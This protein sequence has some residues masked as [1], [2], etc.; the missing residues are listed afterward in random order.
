MAKAKKAVK[1]R[2]ASKAQLAAL[3]RGR[4][5]AAANRKSASPKRKPRK[6][7][8]R[9]IRTI[10][11]SKPMARRKSSKAVAK[12][13]TKRRRSSGRG[14]FI[15]GKAK[16]MIPIVKDVAIAVGGGVAGG[17]LANK[18]PI[19][20]PK[21]K[22]ALPLVAGILL[23]STLGQKKRIMHELGTGMAVIGAIALLKQFAP[24]IPM[25]AGEDEVILIPPG[26][27]GDMMRL[28][29]DDDNG[30][31]SQMGDM[32]NLGDDQEEYMS[33]ANL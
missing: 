21:I 27:G 26:Y 13:T 9:K 2:K 19:A 32:F 17:V 14:N 7:T 12:T 31:L 29:Y 20:N 22:A 6:K 1:K 4:K 25:L 16:G 8:S 30:D 23:A 28:G 5:K 15:K 24:N 18:L 11:E 33:P 3:A 10:K